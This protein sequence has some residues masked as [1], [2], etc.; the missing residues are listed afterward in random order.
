M[1]TSLR[2]IR[3]IALTAS[4]LAMLLDAAAASPILTQSFQSSSGRTNILYYSY[5]ASPCGAGVSCNFRG[6]INVPKAFDQAEVFLSG[7]QLQAANQ[8][9]A[10]Q[11]V[12]V[13]VQKHSYD[14]A[15]GDIDLSLSAGLRTKSGQGYT[16]HISFTVLLTATNLA[17]F[18]PISSGCAGTHQ[19]SINRSLP[20]AVPSGMKYIGLATQ[21]WNLASAKAVPLLLNT[22]SGHIDS[23][24]V[25][26]PAVNL[27]FLCAMQA[28]KKRNDMWCEW[29]AKIIAFD[30]AELEPAVIPLPY[31]YT[32]LSWNTGSRRF[33]SNHT[34]SPSRQP[35]AGFLDAF[36][37]L[38]LTYQ[39]YPQGGP[40]IQNRI[41]MIESTADNFRID[42]AFPDTAVTNYGIFLG[43]MFGNTTATAPYA[44]QES[45]AFGFLK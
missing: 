24:T 13:T 34:T 39:T 19:C 17:L 7:F 30:P 3:A 16:I 32:F 28:G 25:T 15:T 37:G 40:S 35:I 23:L 36:E 1:K 43:S 27:S 33:W 12:S 6:N 20:V 26:P 42:P 4:I 31:Q 29:G 38:T 22:L 44:Y 18:T 11:Q 5:D 21:N 14:P 8:V 10:L 2:F 41:W 9:D 45:R